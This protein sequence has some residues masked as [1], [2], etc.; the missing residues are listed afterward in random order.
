MTEKTA[1]N[2]YNFSSPVRQE[3]LFF[4]Q[5]ALFAWM[6]INLE[7]ISGRPWMVL[8]GEQRTGKSSIL[9]QIAQG[10]LGEGV[11]PVLVDV[12]QLQRESLASFYRSLAE[13]AVA[14]LRL[15]NLTLPVFEQ[16]S[17]VE[18]PSAA[19]TRQLLQPMLAEKGPLKIL[20]LFDNV[21]AALA[22]IDAGLLPDDVLQNL[23]EL[24][25]A[26]EDVYALFA[27]EQST[28]EALRQSLV[29]LHEA[30]S[31]SVP[32]LSLRAATA[33]IRQPV[34]YTVVQAVAEYIYELAGGNPF[35][36][37][38]YCHALYER[39]EAYKL[40]T[41]TVAD[42]VAV[43]PWVQQMQQQM[44]P[45][46]T[47][48][49][50]TETAVPLTILPPYEL[51]GADMTRR[52][53][54]P[55]AAK[56]K[57]RR[58]LLL[59]LLLLILLLATAGIFALWQNEP[60]EPLI[61]EAETPTPTSLPTLT[62]TP[63]VPP[64]AVEPST[65]PLPTITPLPTETA[66]PSPTAT[67]TPTAEPVS[68]ELAV[69]P[70]ATPLPSPITREKDGM[71]MVYVPAGSFLMGSLDEDFM[72]ASDEK[73]QRLVEMDAFFIDKYEV[74]VAQYAAFLNELGGYLQACGRRDCTLP[75]Q[76][77]GFT[78]YLMEETAEDGSLIFVAM[79]GFADYP[80]NHISWYGAAAYC[81]YVGGRLPT[82]AEW[83]YAARGT[84]GRLY[85]WGNEPPN[86]FVAVYMSLSFDNVKPV[87]ALPDG[88]SPFGAEGMAGSMWEWTADW[89]DPAYYRSG[90][91]ANPTGPNIGETK[92][93]R[94]GAWPN[95]N[96]ADRIR[97][98]NRTGFD[99]T[100]IS[101]SVGFRCAFS[102]SSGS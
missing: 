20:F 61:I 51:A 90:P 6:K 45:Q 32:P 27:L 8:F 50:E 42:V 71:T 15:H 47:Q 19:F 80:A 56:K 4:G 87:D 30:D 49:A 3:W 11:L 14:S 95:N 28:E 86:Q 39:Q 55:K 52:K 81:T 69:T 65:T 77:V 84:D 24:L 57:N 33:L 48:Q 100:Y 44:Q 75:R 31:Q 66:V 43:R 36:L 10:R 9:W 22:S 78:N 68:M 16:T 29:F 67:T 46:P 99:P 23:G 82:E 18:N 70:I 34:S 64:L 7:A 40:H 63:I 73:P 96:E 5:E 53:R 98:A 62:L 21:E 12:A 38:L 54:Q 97:T 17:F 58:R 83:E 93:A 79:P 101:A 25:R 2:P 85:P 92:S 76:R 26:H 37:Q 13:T 35:V 74:S 59:L 91:A 41:I 94:G 102:P 60:E 72:A 88:A 1:Q 89:Y